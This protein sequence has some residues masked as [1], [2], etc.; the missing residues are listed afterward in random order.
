METGQARRTLLYPKGTYQTPSFVWR[1]CD[2]TD[3]DSEYSLAQ[4]DLKKA[5]EAMEKARKEFEMVQKAY[6]D[7]E[8]RIV[9]L[10]ESLGGNSSSTAEHMR[11]RKGIAELTIELEDIEM[12]LNETQKNSSPGA[13][14]Q[15][16]QEKMTY[17]VC[18]QNLKQQ[19]EETEKRIKQQQ[20][21]LFEILVSDEWRDATA[22]ATEHQITMRIK[23]N[24]DRN[25]TTA[26]QE[27]NFDSKNQTPKK[28]IIETNKPDFQKLQSLLAKRA[29]L[30]QEY[31]KA[32]HER[33]CA[34]IRR[35]VTLACMLDE[36]QRLDATLK[37]L[38]DEGIDVEQYRKAYLPEGPLSPLKRPKSSDAS[39]RGGRKEPTAG[40][41]TGRSK[42]DLNRPIRGCLS[43]LGGGKL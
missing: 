24:M 11:L 3:H 15:L 21:E 4:S 12:K 19:I 43:P 41:G 8:K 28:K 36:L 33:C 38:G 16:E 26:F 34:Q 17:F 25:V 39:I 13:I 32:Q 22:I 23:E 10:A 30:K 6:N 42:S 1:S 31:Q 18:I 7:K 35:K 5:K 2:E 27:Q 20:R 40:Q 37:S 29:L 14:L 9:E